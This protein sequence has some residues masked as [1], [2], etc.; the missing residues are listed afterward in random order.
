MALAQLSYAWEGDYQLLSPQFCP[1]LYLSGWSYLNS[2]ME[3][4]IKTKQPETYS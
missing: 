1:K 3:K 2:E 4:K